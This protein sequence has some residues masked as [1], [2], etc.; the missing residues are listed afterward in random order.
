MLPRLLCLLCITYIYISY[1]PYI[2]ISYKT[3]SFVIKKLML[4]YTVH[5]RQICLKSQNVLRITIVHK[6]Y[7]LSALKS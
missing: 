5:E 6:S 2:T 4:R 7:V 1:L 3:M